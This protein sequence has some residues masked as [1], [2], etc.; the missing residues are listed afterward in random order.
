MRS[1]DSLEVWV[2]CILEPRGNP[3]TSSV[4]VRERSKNGAK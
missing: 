2:H 1:G 4:S 3:Q